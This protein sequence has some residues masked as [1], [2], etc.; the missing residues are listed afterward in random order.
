MRVKIKRSGSIFIGA[1]VF[2]GVAAANTG[3]N[4][5]YIIVSSMLALMFV[6]GIT[7]ILNIRGIEVRL[8]PPQEVFSNRRAK[9][10]IVLMKKSLFPSFLIKV[11]SSV[12]SALFPIVDRS[13]RE[14]FLDFLFHKRGYVKSI[15]IRVS[16]DFPLGMF[17]R[18]I[19][20]EVKVDLVVFP[21]PISVRIPYT[22]SNVTREGS[23]SKLT[24]VKG[25]EEL[26][27]VRDYLGDPM[28]LIHW[29]LSAKKGKL[30]VRDMLAEEKEPIVLSLD[31]V[32][33]DLETKI[34]KLA[35]LTIK[36]IGDGYPVGLKLGDKDIP[37][38]R[39]DRQKLII[40]KELA[41]Y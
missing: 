34:S 30:M 1:T 8:V 40:L 2:L 26:K 6:S 4:L 9:F 35:Y 31:M 22:G 11:S 19:D 14:G 13:F 41:L 27:G 5:L 23:S 12:E 29:K 24:L 25:Y 32:E 17:V 33:G 36:L 38:E 37:P 7:S 28:K 10:R 16:S 21:E 20:L 18:Y 39:G 15:S 3:N